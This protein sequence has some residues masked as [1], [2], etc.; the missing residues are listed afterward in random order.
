MVFHCCQGKRRFVG[1]PSGKKPCRGSV[2][3]RQEGIEDRHR[4]G[5]ARV[6]VEQRP[7]DERLVSL[8]QH[9]SQAAD[10]A[11][12]RQAISMLRQQC[13]AD[14]MQ[15]RLMQVIDL[16]ADTSVQ[17]RGSCNAVP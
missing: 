8:I 1:I 7:G 16:Q 4:G 10:E 12:F 9:L 5:Q 14:A 17:H 2:D 11:L 3:G 6:Q 15:Q 13:M